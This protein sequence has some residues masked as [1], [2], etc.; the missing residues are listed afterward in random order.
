MEITKKNIRGSPYV[1]IFCTIT[2]KFGLFPKNIERQ[3]AEKLAEFFGVEAIQASIAGTNLLGVLSTAN[4]NGVAI[5]GVADE[6]EIAELK[7]LGLKVAVVNNIAAV[8]NLVRAN[9]KGGVCAKIFSKESKS[10]MEKVL[11]VELRQMEIAGTDLVGSCV[12]A[13]NRGFLVNPN[14]SKENFAELKKIFGVDG[15][16]TTAN[17]GDVCV[18]NSVLANGMAAMVGEQ[19]SGFEL[20]RIDE[21]LRGE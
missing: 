4:A 5:S 2:E 12:V 18:G 11:G 1:G 7:G 9:D 3:E 15:A 16:T 14:V 10:T 8:G 19:T 17:Y 20:M 13:T 21:G 6:R